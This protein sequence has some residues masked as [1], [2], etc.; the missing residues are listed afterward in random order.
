MRGDAGVARFVFDDGET[1]IGAQR[2]V[3]IG[4][5]GEDIVNLAAVDAKPAVAGDQAFTWI[6]HAAFSAAG[7]LHWLTAG[8]DRIIQGNLDS[9]SAP[10]LEILLRAIPARATA[11]DFFL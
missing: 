1:G 7:Q 3:I 4:F 5:A 8:A 9:D 10:E 11:G 2:D 6:G